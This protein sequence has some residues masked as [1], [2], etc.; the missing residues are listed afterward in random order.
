[1]RKIYYKQAH[2]LKDA[3]TKSIFSKNHFASAVPYPANI[4]NQ[5]TS[6]GLS[7]VAGNVYEC[8]SDRSFWA[9]KDGKIK[10]LVGNEVDNG[11]SI[12]AAPDDRP[13]AF[14]DN[15]MSDLEF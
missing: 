10:K 2:G 7:R 3:T 4:Q 8:P 13:Q 5:I 11:E 14:I 1:M 9:V 6:W 15:I 12:T